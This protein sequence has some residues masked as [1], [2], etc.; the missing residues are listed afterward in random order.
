M[1]EKCLAG[2]GLAVVTPLREDELPRSGSMHAA[3]LGCRP[4]HGTV[5]GRLDGTNL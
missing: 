2:T 3:F 5:A 4:I 1:Q